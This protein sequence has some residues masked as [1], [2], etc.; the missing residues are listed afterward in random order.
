M[1][2]GN[3]DIVGRMVHDVQVI[4]QDLANRVGIQDAA[5]F[6]ER[7][8]LQQAGIDLLKLSSFIQVMEAIKKAKETA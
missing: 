4:V 6:P 3:N 2:D 5:L 7:E 1:S 8:A